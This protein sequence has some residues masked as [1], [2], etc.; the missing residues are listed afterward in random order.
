MDAAANAVTS[1]ASA[2]GLPKYAVGN[3]LVIYRIVEEESEVR[4]VHIFHAMQNYIEIQKSE[5]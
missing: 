4:V 3:Y 2:Q 1:L 5:I